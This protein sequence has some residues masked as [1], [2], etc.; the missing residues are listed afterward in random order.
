MTEV[1]SYNS[2]FTDLFYFHSLEHWLDNIYKWIPR[3]ST[4]VLLCKIAKV[5]T[6][7][8]PEHSFKRGERIANLNGVCLGFLASSTCGVIDCIGS[9][10]V[11]GRYNA[12]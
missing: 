7:T 1:F 6:I 5:I 3:G 9:L 4:G 2:T 8:V 12:P 11:T 10:T